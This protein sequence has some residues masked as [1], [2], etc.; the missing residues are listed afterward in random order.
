MRPA[1]RLWLS[2]IVLCLSTFAIPLDDTIASVALRALPRR[3]G[4][5]R[6]RTRRRPSQHQLA[7]LANPKKEGPLS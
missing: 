6:P 3:G 5:T 7:E 1:K 2:L 4:L